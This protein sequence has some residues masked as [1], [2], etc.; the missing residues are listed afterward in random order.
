MTFQ[1]CTEQ[2]PYQTYTKEKYTKERVKCFFWW[3]DGVI[4]CQRQCT[5]MYGP[6]GSHVNK[7]DGSLHY[8]QV[9][10]ENF[11]RHSRMTP[12]LIRYSCLVFTRP[13]GVEWCKLCAAP[14]VHYQIL[15]CAQHRRPKSYEL[16]YTCSCHEEMRRYH[17]LILD[18]MSKLYEHDP[19]ACWSSALTPY[20]A[21]QP[22]LQT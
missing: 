5:C 21:P 14:C 8:S 7:K 11:Q 16:A 15:G 10:L 18:I 4:L 22:C 2:G 19:F 1:K 12:T 17:W 6:S 13:C 3:L 20:I 9:P